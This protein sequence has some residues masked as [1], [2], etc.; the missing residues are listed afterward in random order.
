MLRLSKAFLL[1]LLL[2]VSVV[3]SEGFAASHLFHSNTLTSLATAS[4]TATATTGTTKSVIKHTSVRTDMKSFKIH[5]GGALK[6]AADSSQSQAKCPVS[7]PIEIFGSVWGSLGVV[8]VLVKSIRRVLPIALEPFSSTTTMVLTP[9]QWSMYAMTCLFFAYVEGYKG[10]HLKFSPLVVKRSFTLSLGSKQGSLINYLLAPIYSMGL[11][12]ATKKRL[13]TSWSVSLG[14]AAIVAIV[15]RL[16]GVWR[17]IL[18]GGVIV[19]LSVGSLSILYYFIKSW[20]T[21]SPPNVD[22]CLPELKTS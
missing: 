10:F 2:G 20:A 17:C 6:A 9:F 15:K 4:A 19:G 5:R 7:K 12:H 13:I 8:Y 22:A 1:T 21:G 11:I 18:D 14:V 3:L 16:P